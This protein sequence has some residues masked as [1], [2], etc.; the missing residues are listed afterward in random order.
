LD[1]FKLS[2][3]QLKMLNLACVFAIDPDLLLLDEP[4]SSLDC[5]TKARVCRSIEARKDKITIIFSHERSTLPRVDTISE[6][7]NGRL[8]YR[9]TTPEALFEWKGAPP[10]LRYALKLGSSPKN[11]TLDDAR[12]AICA[13]RD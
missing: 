8:H 11:I 4:F 12:E 7:E 6:I 9:G 5:N 1:P 2:R 13:M 10:Y 3:G